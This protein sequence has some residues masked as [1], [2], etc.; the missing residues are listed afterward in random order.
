V[1]APCFRSV[2][3][4]GHGATGDF[5]SDFV[6]GGAAVL[7]GG[8]TELAPELQWQNIAG[9]IAKG[10]AGETLYDAGTSIGDFGEMVWNVSTFQDANYL[11]LLEDLW[12]A[13]TLQAGWEK[14]LISAIKSGNLDRIVDAVGRGFDSSFVDFQAA[15]HGISTVLKS[16]VLDRIRQGI[17]FIPGIGTVAGGIIGAAQGYARAGLQGLAENAVLG[18][19]PAGAGD[20]IRAAGGLGT[21]SLMAQ[22][23]LDQAA[24]RA[25]LGALQAY[26][27]VYGPGVANS[28]MGVLGTLAAQFDTATIGA[29]LPDL[30]PTALWIAAQ[31]SAA[32][33]GISPNPP[34]LNLDGIHMPKIMIPTAAQYASAIKSGPNAG[35]GLIDGMDYAT[36]LLFQ[37]AGG[38]LTSAGDREFYNQSMQRADASSAL[39]AGVANRAASA[40]SAQAAYDASLYNEAMTKADASYGAAQGAASR[41]AGG[42]DPSSYAGRQIAAQAKASASPKGTG[43]AIARGLTVSQLVEFQAAGGELADDEWN[44]LVKA[45]SA[46]AASV[47]TKAPTSTTRKA[48]GMEIGGGAP[49]D[50]KSVKPAAN[51]GGTTAAGSTV[52]PV[53]PDQNLLLWRA[54]FA[55]HLAS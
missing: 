47:A 21:I 10:G 44:A 3:G 34:D 28:A 32:N 18:A 52:P 5:L 9:N 39:A 51:S 30:D 37:Q 8:I 22:G 35:V 15:T 43:P 12:N 4:N 1:V 33:L 7:S 41:A 50:T 14:D 31:K 26:I 2:H 40:A 36:A 13:G 24:E 45:T 16:P 20:A 49:L 54:Y 42:Y 48:G 23:K 38:E 46:G 55:A 27:P 29:I 53:T 25:A 19:L 11:G 17:T 6:R